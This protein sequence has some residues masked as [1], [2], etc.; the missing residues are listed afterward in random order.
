MRNGVRCIKTALT[1]VGFVFVLSTPIICVRLAMAVGESSGGGGVWDME[2][3]SGDNEPSSNFPGMV[4]SKSNTTRYNCC[5]TKHVKCAR[6]IRGSISDFQAAWAIRRD[7]PSNPYEQNIYNIC[8]NPSTNTGGYVV[9]MGLVDTYDYRNGRLTWVGNFGLDNAINF[10]VSDFNN[11]YVIGQGSGYIGREAADLVNK[12]MIRKGGRDK[13]AFACEHTGTP[14]PPT[15]NLCT[16]F[17][18]GDTTS[19]LAMVQNV[20]TGSGW[21]RGDSN[22]NYVWAK[23][24]DI[25]Q[26]H[27][28]YYSGVQSYA[29]KDATKQTG[30]GGDKFVGQTSNGTS[31]NN[32]ARAPLSTEHGAL[33]NIITFENKYTI[34]GV[35]SATRT[36][37]VG[38]VVRDEYEGPSVNADGTSQS[39]QE[40]H[41]DYLV[42]TGDIGTDGR[43]NE[44]ITSGTPSQATIT[45][46]NSSNGPTTWTCNHWVYTE[47]TPPVHIPD[48]IPTGEGWEVVANSCNIA[49]NTCKYTRT[50][51]GDSTCRLTEEH[52]YTYE[53]PVSSLA[54]VK[55][56]HN[57]SNHGEVI[58][59]SSKIYAGEIA[60]I[61]AKIVTD[62]RYNGVTQGWYA[63]RV[64]NASWSVIG[65]ITDNVEGLVGG[66][67]PVSN[68]ECRAGVGN[69]AKFASGSGSLNSGNAGGGDVYNFLN[70]QSFSVWDVEAG[71]YFCVVSTVYP[72]ETNGDTDI[73]GG[74]NGQWS[75]PRGDCKIIRKKPTFQVWG[76]DIFT[77]GV[78]KS[79]TP[80]KNNLFSVPNVGDPKY[81]YSIQNSTRIHFEGFGEHNVI[82]K[83]KIQGVFSGNASGFANSG[84]IQDI[85]PK[86]NCAHVPLSFSNGTCSDTGSSDI[87]SGT[88]IYDSMMTQFGNTAKNQTPRT[89]TVDISTTFDNGS[90]I[91]G[92]NVRYTHVSSTAHIIASG[93]IPPQTTHIVY[94]DGNGTI[95]IDSNLLYNNGLAYTEARQV[96][97]LIIITP[98]N[99]T[100]KDNVTQIDGWLLSKGTITTGT[101]QNDAG[102]AASMYPLRINGPVY[103]EKIAL[104]RAYG[105]TKGSGSGDPAEI[106]NYSP[107]VYLYNAN[108][109]T[110]T[111]TLYTTYL[112]EV[113]PRY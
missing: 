38:K 9:W 98:G 11:G 54:Y 84:T 112:K 18:S 19:V 47:T 76:G 49:T 44:T 72:S 111:P 104:N 66:S 107:F 17:G 50:T 65:Y 109:S 43:V 73:S 12:E 58:I 24:N 82:A 21:K 6:W 26:F 37:N 59:N 39:S 96:P 90:T 42:S 87:S 22:E 7:Y 103:A 32:A 86:D 97:Q 64:P 106:M 101:K 46:Y 71:K 51:S 83:G 69:C 74:G 102:N 62:G 78:L 94:A 3:C 4:Q 52:V 14:P 16:G 41:S 63:T 79:N 77:N 93:F 27:H 36:F 80:T 1:L 40:K 99:I 108:R 48:G 5:S 8:T 60:Q 13:V 2:G 100:I 15:Y 92:T 110:D 113:A 34:S 35:S 81:P 61:S 75:S 45:E 56:P 31:A 20:S 70:N 28:C 23:P 105:A 68:G 30:V 85:G 67:V 10:K 55:V 29:D 88:S 95:A 25:I 33:K 57:Y 91:G 89:G 53:G